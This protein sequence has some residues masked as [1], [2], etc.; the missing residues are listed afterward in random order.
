[1][2]SDQLLVRLR[3]VLPVAA[4]KPLVV[5]DGHSLQGAAHRDRPH[6]VIHFDLHHLPPVAEVPPFHHADI[7]ARDDRALVGVESSAVD[8]LIVLEALY[9]GASPEVKEAEVSVFAA[10]VDEVLL[11]PKTSD[12]SDIAFEVSLVGTELLLGSLEVVDLGAVVH[13]DDDLA[14]VLSDLDAVGG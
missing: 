10:S 5:G 11:L 13:A 4:E 3:H 7:I 14:F 6:A 2:G 1:M 8:W 9:R 12:R